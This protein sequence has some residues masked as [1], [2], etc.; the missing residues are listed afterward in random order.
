MKKIIV[1]F[2]F[3]ILIIP[4]ITLASSTY[5]KSVDIA[6][7]YIYNFQDY[8]R[9]VKLTGELPYGVNSSNKPV[10]NDS[11]KTGGLLNQREYTVSIK[12]GTSWLA[13]GISFWLADRKELDVKANQLVNPN[14]ESGVRVTEFII[15]DASVKGTGTKTNP[16]NFVE[17]YSVKIGS[18]NQAFGT[19][20]GGC[21]HV[22]DNGTCS[23]NVRYNSEQGIDVNDCKTI[24]ESKGSQFEF[25]GNDILIKNIHNDISCLINFG[26]SDKCVELSFD[27]LGGTG[28]TTNSIYYRYGFGWYGDS[29]C[30]SKVNSLTKPSKTGYDFDGYNADDIPIIDRDLKIVAGSRENI[31][32]SRTIKAVWKPITYT[33]TYVL[34]GGANPSGAKTTYTIEDP[35][36]DL[37]TP[38]KDNFLFQGWYTENIGGTK[39]TKIETGSHGNKT[40]YARWIPSKYKLKVV[41]ALGGTVYNNFLDPNNGLAFGKFTVKIDGTTVATDVTSFEQD[42]NYGSSYSITIKKQ[43]HWKIETASPVT[44]TM[45]AE[46]KTIQLDFSIAAYNALNAHGWGR[47]DKISFP[48]GMS[49]V[50]TL[51]VGQTFTVRFYCPSDYNADATVGVGLKDANYRQINTTAQGYLNSDRN[52]FDWVSNVMRSG[53][54]RST[55][56]RTTNKG[57]E[58]RSCICFKYNRNTNKTDRFDRRFLLIV[59]N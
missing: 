36:F 35:T 18:S 34:D 5:D 39:V 21:E 20:I 15:S 26:T 19:V 42:V 4:T 53:T 50:V 32:E 12:N 37:P 58:I 14:A 2:L 27:N 33:I 57:Y 1:L 24:V 55:T 17:G 23:F 38:T 16:W 45:P 29:L 48:S 7:K 3:L 13:P 52:L 31:T 30:L 49:D 59:T 9:F 43:D 28:G 25:D 41:G 47:Q 46:N 54:L 40:Y 22:K 56:L 51:R 10:Y 44:G 8:S 11:F 6:N